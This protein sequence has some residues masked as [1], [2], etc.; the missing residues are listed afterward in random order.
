[1]QRSLIIF[2]GLTLILATVF[3]TL[4]INL[5]DG[6]IVIEEPHREYTIQA[7]LSLS[8]FIGIGYEEADML[9]VKDFYLTTKGVLMAVIFIVG[10]PAI[11]A[12]RSSLSRNK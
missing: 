1:M 4:P 9:H 6:E 2:F 3:F 5:F 10:L 12:Y 7:R 11:L 8:Y